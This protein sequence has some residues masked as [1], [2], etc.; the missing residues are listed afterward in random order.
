MFEA[1]PDIINSWSSN[2][3]SGL[4][5][6]NF[7][8]KQLYIIICGRYTVSAYNSIFALLLII[9]K[10]R[11]RISMH[12]NFFLHYLKRCFPRYTNVFQVYTLYANNDLFLVI[13]KFLM[14]IRVFL[15]FL[16]LNL[17]ARIRSRTLSFYFSEQR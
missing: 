16:G 11:A 5:G 2:Y 1:E 7:T 10:F 6:N 12:L 4:T 9:Y 8:L 17:L 14:F 13:L 15:N 3:P